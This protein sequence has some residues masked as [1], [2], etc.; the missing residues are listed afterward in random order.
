MNEN[1][2]SRGMDNLPGSYGT[3][4]S[5]E[6]RHELVAAELVLKALRQLKGTLPG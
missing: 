5:E 1:L 2:H 4:L 6:T 3:H